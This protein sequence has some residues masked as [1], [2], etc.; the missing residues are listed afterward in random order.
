MSSSVRRKNVYFVENRPTRTISKQ[1]SNMSS[2]W[3]PKQ[4]VNPTFS[5]TCD[6][7]TI[8]TSYATSKISANWQCS[9]IDKIID[10]KTLYYSIK[11]YVFWSVTFT[12][13]P[14]FY[15]IWL[16]L[17]AWQCIYTSLPPRLPWMGHSVRIHLAM[18]G[19][20]PLLAHHARFSKM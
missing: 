15:L 12:N 3:I 7:C 9:I 19:L 20:I 2:W 11:M 1:I 5:H 17:Y 4:P 8:W 10:Y 18:D 14:S 16:Q 13:G 6:K